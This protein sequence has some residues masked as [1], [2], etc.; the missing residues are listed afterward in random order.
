MEQL[1]G[2]G[3]EME[4]SDMSFSVSTQ[5]KDS[6]RGCEWGNGNGILG[7]LAQKTNILK[8]SFWRMVHEII[9]FKNDALMYLEDP[10][11]HTNMGAGAIPVCTGTWSCSPQDVLSLSAFFV[12]SFCRNN[13]LLQLFRHTQLPTVKPRSQSYVN[14]V[15]R[16]LESMGCRIKTSCRVKSVSSLDGA[17]GYR[18]L[19]NDGSEETFDSVILGVHAPNALKVLGAEATHQELRILGACQYVQRDIYLHCDQNLMPRNPSA[20]SAWNFLGTTSRGFSVTYW[21]NQIQKIESVRPFLVTLNPPGVPDHVLLKWN[22]SLPVPSAAAAKAY[23]QLDQIQGKREIWFCGAYQGHGFHEDGLMAGKAAAQG[24]LGKKCELLLYPKQI[25]PSWTVAGARLAFARFFMQYI[26]IGNLILVEAGGSVFSFGKACNKCHVKSVVRVHDPLFYW[27]ATTEGEIGLGEAYING[28]F[29]CLDKREGLLNFILSNDFFS[30]FLDKSMTYSCAVFKMENE[31]LE[32]AQ[33]RKLSLLID[34]AKVEREHHVLDIG[35]G[36]G[37]LAIQVVKQTGCKYTGV[38]L[39]EEQLKYAESKVREA[40]LEDHITFLLCDYRLIPPYKYDAIISCGMIEHVGHEY[41]DEF[42]ACCES[43]LAEDGILVLQFISIAEE[44]YE[45][46]R[47][48]PHFVKEYIFPGGCIPSLARVM[49]AMTTSS[50]F[51]IEHVENIGPNYYTTLMH[52]RDNFMANKDQVLELGFDEQFI[53][54]WEFYLMYS[55]AGFK[56]RAVGDY[57]IYIYI[58][59]HAG[60][61]LSSRQPSARPALMT[62]CPEESPTKSAKSCSHHT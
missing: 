39:S 24:L 31:S 53:R 19:E 14:K 27:K 28:Y 17:A 4:R 7:L 37:S 15:K 52:W 51:S 5:L 23:L 30:L 34:K 33:Q 35:S 25:I 61:F 47:R 3:V 62:E 10:S 26:S 44:R 50:R 43:Y 45:Q 29:S 48:R 57:Q 21:L 11:F 49:S 22:I 32:A 56:S 59:L 8:P 20:W 58:Y 55:A 6:G 9:K 16:E 42:F 40:G 36:W 41:M 46:Y 54:I 12:L 18:V 38:T 1:E 13:D 60:C 2:L